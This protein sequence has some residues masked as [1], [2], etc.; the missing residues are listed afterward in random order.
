MNNARTAV[1][2]AS[3]LMFL[4]T[5]VLITSPSDA[6][7][8]GT[9]DHDQGTDGLE[10]Y[11]DPIDN[12]YCEV[13]GYNGDAKEVVIPSTYNGRN[14]M[15]FQSG[16]FEG[17]SSITKV[18]LPSSITSIPGNAFRGCISLTD[19]VIPS[20]LTSVGS[21]AFEG[22]I[23]LESLDLPDTLS[24][25]PDYMFRGCTSL[26]TLEIPGSVNS[27]GMYAFG[28]PDA[29]RRGDGDQMGYLQRLLLPHRS[30]HP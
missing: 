1:L 24:G 10:F 12:S 9:G 19:V 17:N 4:A 6:V 23:S 27:I 18:T 25:I 14:V 8:E 26:V 15:A 20:S 7:D 29:A 5:V 13:T 11:E 3:L 28:D 2:T 30:D 21:N 16:V 22:C